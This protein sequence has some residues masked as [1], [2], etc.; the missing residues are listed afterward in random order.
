[1]TRILRIVNNMIV[2][3]EVTAHSQ[4]NTNFIT[5]ELRVCGV[6]GLPS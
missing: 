5:V 3:S 4:V 2:R 6:D 1:M